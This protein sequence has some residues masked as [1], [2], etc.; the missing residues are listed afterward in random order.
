MR[1]NC[2]ECQSTLTLTTIDHDGD[3]IG[4]ECRC[5]YYVTR[6]TPGFRG[7]ADWL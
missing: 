3:L 1:T 6:Y 2:E 5:G 7:E 4:D